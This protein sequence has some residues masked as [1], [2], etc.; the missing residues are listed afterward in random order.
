MAN[1]THNTHAFDYI[2]VGAGT[3]GCLLAN[4]LSADPANRVLLIEAG[5]RDNYHWIH[6]PIGYLYCI[7]NPRT[8]WCLRTEPDPGLNGRSLIYPRGKT[9]G[10]CSSING[11][12]YMRG[13]A[14]DYD[15]WAELTGDAAWRWENCL[16]D[17]MK[18]E[19]HYRL[20]EGGDADD[21]HR[22]FHGHGGEW[23]VEKQ[24]LKWQVLDDFATAAVEAG[25][26]R[27]R[28]FNRGDNEG[29]DYFEVNQRSGWR[30][31]TS[32]AFLR[33]V[34]QR[35]NLTVWHST[36]V[37]GLEVS[38]NDGAKPRC[39]GVT[40]ER[41]GEKVVVTASR[42]VVLSAGAIGSPQLLQLSGIGPAA[43]LAEHEIPVMTDLPGVGEN[44]QDHLQIRA[45]YRVKGASTLNTLA[46]SWLGKARIALEYGLKRSG[47]MSMA[48][49]QLCAFTRSAES[50]EHPNLEYH[51]QPLSLEAFGQPLHDFPAITASVCNLNPTSRGR[52]RIKS[53]DPRQAPAISPNY[54]STSEDRQVAADSLRVTRHIAAQPAFAKYAPEEVKPGVQYQ[55]DDD[56]ARLAGDIGTTIFHPVGTARMGHEDDPMAVVD[57]RLRVRGV[58]GL[59]VVDASIMP[60]ITSGNTNSP[61]LM[62]AEKAAGWILDEA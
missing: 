30:W 60:T 22:D 35:G 4:R 43:L 52:V 37:L 48:P 23:R 32:K 13:Q 21:V 27:I 16:P 53:R 39:G 51:V 12:L 29:V 1:N 19:D 14:R 58:Q 59:R 31:N 47:P 40:V 28:D 9:L 50:Y 6:I 36:Q 57:S 7:N 55:S 38:T 20:D 3:A 62:I 41:A 17:F 26:P 33:G 42:E 45:V 61:T 44:L 5:G 10:G 25:I 11:M 24:R 56:L 8:D 18:H 46:G 54:L 2:V 15:G 49:S 34:E